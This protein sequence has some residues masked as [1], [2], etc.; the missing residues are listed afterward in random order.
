MGVYGEKGT[1]SREQIAVLFVHIAPPGVQGLRLRVKVSG[2]QVQD[3]GFRIQGPGFRVQDVVAD[4]LWARTVWV[5]VCNN[6]LWE[7]GIGVS[8]TRG[9]W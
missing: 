4:R 2:F 9:R 6:L 3:S 7:M 1:V 8:T 5:I